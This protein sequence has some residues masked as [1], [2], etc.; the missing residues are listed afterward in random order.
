MNTDAGILIR[1]FGRL[2]VRMSVSRVSLRAIAATLVGAVC[3]AVAFSCF[4]EGRQA[5]E[6]RRMSF[7]EP[8]GGKEAA[9]DVQECRSLDTK[10][11]RD[12]VVTAKK[13]SPLKFRCGAETSL[14][15]QGPDFNSVYLYAP[16]PDLKTCNTTVAVGLA[17]TVSTA[18]LTQQATQVRGDNTTTPFYVFEYTADPDSDKHLCYTCNATN[19]AASEDDHREVSLTDTVNCTVFIKVPKATEEKPPTDSSTAAPDSPSGA[20]AAP[21]ALGAAVGGFV[22]VMLTV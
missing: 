9:D 12:L 5:S 22:A 17:E 21:A 14:S 2:Q 18:K 10:T 19:A 7:K 8:G 13:G 16:A 3:L 1:L 15:P 11:K 20:R 6:I 4:A